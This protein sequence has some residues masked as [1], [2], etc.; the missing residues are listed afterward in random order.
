MFS[1]T[2]SKEVKGDIITTL[3]VMIT[4]DNKCSYLPA[5]RKNSVLESLTHFFRKM[6]IKNV[7]VKG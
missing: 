3:D 2:F 6:F 1:H 5:T 7:L 4:N